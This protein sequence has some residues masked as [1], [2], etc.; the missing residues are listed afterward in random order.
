ME[1]QLLDLF[2]GDSMELA[3]EKIDASTVDLI[4]TDFSCL[5]SEGNPVGI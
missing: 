4:F 1:P 5:L 3:S 2:C